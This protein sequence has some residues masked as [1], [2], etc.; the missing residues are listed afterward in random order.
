MRHSQRQ[1][2]IHGEIRAERGR[3]GAGE[4]GGHQPVDVHADVNPGDADAEPAHPE[5]EAK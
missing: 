3:S 4:N 2:G 1:R 5:R